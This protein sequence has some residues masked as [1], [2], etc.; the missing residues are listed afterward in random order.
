[1][2][3]DPDRAVVPEVADAPGDTSTP[4][5]ISVGDSFEGTISSSDV[6]FIAINL[7]EGQLIQVSVTGEDPQIWVSDNNGN[8]IE[9]NDDIDF[10]G[11]NYDS[12]LTFEAT[13]TGT[14]YFEVSGYNF[15]ASDY[16]LA[17][18]TFTPIADGSVQDMADFLTT[19]YWASSGQSPRAFDTS[20]SNVISVDI[21]SLS[22]AGQQLA[23]WAFEAWELVADIQFSEVNSGADIT[24]QDT[25]AGAWSTS[26][27]SAGDIL[28]S[29][30]NV[31]TSWLTQFGT[32]A[33]SYSFQT[34]I[35]EI[36]HALGLG[37]QG[38]YNGAAE[39]GTD[40]TFGND[41]WQMSIMSYF[42]QVDS[43]G[44]DASYANIISAMMVDIVAIQDLYGAAGASSASA[45]DTVWGFNSNLGGFYGDVFNGVIPINSPVSM[46]IYDQGGTDLL[47]MR[48]FAQDTRIDMRA[49][50]F[51]DFGG[52]IG[53]L[54]IALG[55]VIENLNTG[56]GVDRVTGNNVANIIQTN[57]GNDW[58]NAAGGADSIRGGTGNDTL[59]GGADN[60]TMFGDGGHDLLGGSSGADTM[61]GGLGFD[62]LSGGDGNDF[63]AGGAGEDRLSG[64]ND[65][66]LLNGGGGSDTLFGGQGDDDLRGGYGSD[67][68]FG[69]Q[70]DDTMT[71]GGGLDRLSGGDGGDILSGGQGADTLLGDSGRDTMNGGA[72]D[73][74]LEGGLG[75]DVLSGGDENDTLL[76]GNGSDILNGGTGAD[77]LEG[78]SGNDTL[79]GGEGNDLLM[80]GAG[81]DMLTFGAG[82]DVGY[83]GTGADTFV[84]SLGVG[85]NNNVADFSVSDGDRLQLDDQLWTP[86][87]GGPVLTEA[88]V[89][90]A[91]GA[92]VGGD[93]VL[94][95]GPDI[96]TLTG[97][98]GQFDASML[99]IV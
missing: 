84:F 79:S 90:T 82:D 2:I 13:Y 89:I 9:Y 11:G 63:L 41:S 12:F 53:N 3:G 50:E 26:T 96:I 73:D 15:V 60:D 87:I 22:A 54:A 95:F 19:G 25:D 75:W 24:F 48:M 66:D 51:S 88:D 67:Q 28:S 78:D 27:V 10:N 56:A 86:P 30:V 17:V 37:H 92:D 42:D 69:G 85:S 80:G 72:G 68:L 94:S 8:T 6:D 16:T 38:A 97:M 70:G 58:V 43:L 1:M 7:T 5:T 36:G 93:F 23:R 20:G 57:E 29:T 32:T 81:R 34:Y 59:F 64:G 18:D 77:Q 47:D 91:F 31:S 74:E 76:G 98:A 35:H 14:Y 21:T 44:T 52:Q 40:E 62:T 83:G 99:D 49:G 4:Y 61:F 39:Y 33:N 55:T 46:T 65:N 71:G 45:G